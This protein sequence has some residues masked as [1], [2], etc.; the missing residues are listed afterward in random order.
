VDGL[1]KIPE[2]DEDSTME[3][4]ARNVLWQMDLDR[5]TKA[6]KQLQGHIMREGY[7][8]GTLKGQ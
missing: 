3:A 4:V 2:N 8:N 7:E 6:L 5:K 1:V